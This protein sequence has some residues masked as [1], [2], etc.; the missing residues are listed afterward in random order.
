VNLDALRAL[1]FLEEA[2]GALELRLADAVR[3]GDGFLDEVATHLISAGGKRL[4]PA[5]ALAA[6][7]GGGRPASLADLDGA[8]AVELVHLAS[9][10]HDDVMDEAP[11]R[12]SVPSVNARFGNL[13]AIVAGDFLLARSAE[14]AAGLGAEV[15]RLLAHTLARLCQGQLLEVQAAY[16]TDRTQS[17]YLSAIEGKTAALMAASCRIGAMT[18]GL[19][20]PQAD[21]LA[22]YGRAFG[23]AFQLRDDVLDVVGTEEELG[24]PPGQDLAEGVYTLPVLV[25]LRDPA[26]GPE[27]AA[28]LGRPLAEPERSKARRIVAASPGIARAEALA[29]D[30]AARAVEATTPLDPMLGRALAELATSLVDPVAPR[31]A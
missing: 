7:T 25:A 3:S 28:L 2:L 12:R 16:R 24:K 4:R 19:G 21:A 29:R 11:M 1:P 30:Y 20:P 14:L 17:S 23:M 6:A 9:L 8:V 26:L 18:G 5:L 27:L 15:A 13:V 10:Y 22:T 31:P